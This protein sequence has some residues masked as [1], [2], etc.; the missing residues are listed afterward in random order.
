M[1]PLSENSRYWEDA[2]ERVTDA[3]VDNIISLSD[4]EILQECIEDGEDPKEIADKMRNIIEKARK[5]AKS[6]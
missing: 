2:L 4:E 5:R 6:K 3:M 1:F